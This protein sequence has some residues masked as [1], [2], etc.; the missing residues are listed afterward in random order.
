VDRWRNEDAFTLIELLTT[1][2]ILGVLAGF[3]IPA[4][5]RQA[6]LARVAIVETDLRNAAAAQ[7]SLS[8]TTGS[9]ADGL[10]DLLDQGF[11]PSADVTFTND[12]QFTA[13]PSGMCMQAE[14]SRLPGHSWAFAADGGANPSEGVC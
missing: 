10:A 1:V 8:I 14:H 4:V 6:D 3:A 5:L 11:R 13:H 7:A 2:L 9:P 12:G